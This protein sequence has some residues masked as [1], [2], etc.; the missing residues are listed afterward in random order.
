MII[1]HR[2][3]TFLPGTLK[4]WLAK[5]ETEG[6]PIQKKHL[7]EF[8]GLFTTE[9]GNLHQVVF[10]WGY[11]SMGDRERRRAKMETDPEWQKFI[12]EIWSMGIIQVQEIK[13]LRPAPFSPIK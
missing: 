12:E 2:T 5:Y 10:M 13:F 11:E 4:R 6:L 8:L 7:G 1:D 3:Y 9:V